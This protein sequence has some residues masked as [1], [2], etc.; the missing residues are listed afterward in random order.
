MSTTLLRSVIDV[1]LEDI[2]VSRVN[3]R[4][5][6][7]EEELVG[8]TESVRSIG[9]IVPVVVRRINDSKFELIAGTRRLRAAERRRSPTIP[10]FVV[11]KDADDKDM[12]IL[13]LSENLHRQDL[14]PFEEAKAILSLCTTFKMEPK[15]VAKRIGKDESFVRG[16][17]K[18]L[19]LPEQVQVMLC[20]QEVNLRH[21]DVLATL[22]R[23]RDQIRY[24]KM[25]AKGKFSRE[26][27]VS[28]LHEEFGDDKKEYGR[29][30]KKFGNCIRTPQSMALKLRRI[31]TFL[32]DR[33]DPMIEPGKSGR[34][35]IVEELERLRQTVSDLLVKAGN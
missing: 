4:A 35:E 1:A 25:V 33:C 16:R 23:P 12:T 8:L 31:R 22:K 28:V 24:A 34:K 30:I 2:I 14:T 6:Y 32:A 26:D 5:H 19:S 29:K 27:L 7:D 10:A 13:A 11:S 9:L 17:L 3:T 21:V 15:E 18:I 20:K